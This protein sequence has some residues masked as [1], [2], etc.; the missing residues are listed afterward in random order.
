L[1]SDAPKGK[2]NVDIRII[3]AAVVL[4]SLSTAA[5]AQQPDA[6]D[7]CASLQDS[8]ARVAC[9]DRAVAARRAAPVAPSTP[10]A[11]VATVPPAPPAAKATDSTVGLD[12][13]QVH[14]LQEARGE[15]KPPPPAPITARL[16]RVIPR[17]P[18]ISA[19]ELDNGQI[20]EQVESM[21][22]L[23]E[24]QELITIRPGLLGAFFLKTADGA[25][26][27]VHRLR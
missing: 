8:T 2:S 17:Q 11:P 10:P 7:A 3:C 13:R 25:V 5:A 12:A 15:A 14:K 19:F 26:V 18:L 6:F 23:P 1:A 4:T 27:R 9:F 24:P 16:V 22:L 21:K 20:W